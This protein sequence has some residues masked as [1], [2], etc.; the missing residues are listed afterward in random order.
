MSNL[1]TEDILNMTGE[2]VVF[3]AKLIATE[4]TVRYEEEFPDEIFDAEL[5]NLVIERAISQLTFQTCNFKCPSE[6]E[7][8]LQLKEYYD[9]WFAAEEE[10]RLRRM[11]YHTI[12]KELDSR[13]RP[14]DELLSFTDRYLRD[15]REKQMKLAQKAKRPLL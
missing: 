15:T 9:E 14:G 4:E 8:E 12:R 7:D 10:H 5:R 6:I 3:K 13:K 1:T 2:I 11:C